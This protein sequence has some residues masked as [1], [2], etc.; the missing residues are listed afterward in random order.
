MGRVELLGCFGTNP[1]SIRV[2]LLSDD[3]SQ[4]FVGVGIASG[5]S[6]T[7]FPVPFEGQWEPGLDVTV[8]ANE[9]LILIVVPVMEKGKVAALSVHAGIWTSAALGAPPEEVPVLRRHLQ[10]IGENL[11]FQPGSHDAKA[12]VHALTVLPHDLVIDGESYRRRLK[13]TLGK[14][15]RR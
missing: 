7:R 4:P 12:L 5:A 1:Y 2:R 13:P 6:Q 8:S 10:T 9:L 3:N 11:E 15:G 14:E